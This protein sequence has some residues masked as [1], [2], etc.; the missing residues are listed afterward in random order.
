MCCEPRSSSTPRDSAGPLPRPTSRRRSCRWRGSSGG[1]WGGRLVEAEPGRRVRPAEG[2]DVKGGVYYEVRS[3][4]LDVQSGREQMQVAM[5]TRELAAN[6][7]TQARD[8]FAAGVAGNIEV[9]Q[10]QE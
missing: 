7:L 8:R 2:E 3:G 1:R 5:R 10:A 4:F 9:V 6:Q